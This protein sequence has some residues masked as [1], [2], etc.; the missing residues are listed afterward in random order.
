MANNT[1]KH[2]LRALLPRDE[3]AQSVA[4]QIEDYSERIE[5]LKLQIIAVHESRAKLEAVARNMA[6]EVVSEQKLTAALARMEVQV[7]DS[8]QTTANILQGELVHLYTAATPF[9]SE[10][11]EPELANAGSLCQ[12]LARWKSMSR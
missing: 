2:W 12:N 5:N 11:V 4:Q 3:R 6:E 8:C 9:L 1:L 10:L 7:L